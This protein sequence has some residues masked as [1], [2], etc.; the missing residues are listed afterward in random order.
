MDFL[1]ENIILVVSNNQKKKMLLKLSEEKQLKN[2]KFMTLK[3]LITSLTF[4]YDEKAIAYLMD[5]YNLKYSNALMYLKNIKYVEDKLYNNEKLDKLVKIKND[6]KPYL[7]YDNLFSKVIKNKKIVILN[8]DYI[9]KYE[10]N[11]LNKINNVEIIN[12]EKSSYIHDVYEFNSINDEIEF[13]SIKICELINS[14]ID[15]N[16]IKIINVNN[17]YIYHIKYIFDMHNIP[18]NITNESSIYETNMVKNFLHL[19]DNDKNILELNY[20]QNDDEEVYIFNKIIEVLNKYNFKTKKETKREMIINDLK[21]IKPKSNKYKNAVE[22]VNIDEV[23]DEDYVFMLNFNQETIPKIYKDEDY[24]SDKLKDIVGIEKSFELNKIERENIINKIKSIKNLTITYKLK[25]TFSSFYPSSLIKDLNYNV[26]KIQ[27]I[28]N[29]YSNFYNKVKLTNKLDNYVKYGD[30]SGNLEKL[31]STYNINYLT[32]SNEFNGINKDHLKEYLNNN[33]NLSYTSMNNY[34]ECKFKYYISN[35]L[36][37]NENEET[38]AKFIGNLFHYILSICFNK[39]FDFELE[40][41]KYTQDYDLTTSNK[42]FLKKLKEELK[43]IIKT[44]EKQYSFSN[45]K[46]AYYEN[47]IVVTNEIGNVKINFKGFIDKLMY[48]KDGNKTLLV[49]IDY[50]T[51]INE[52]NLSNS[53]Y[54]LNLQLPVYLYLA[55]HSNK[56]ENAKVIG[57]YLQKILNS[58]ISI[59]ENKTYEKQKEENLKLQGY[60][61]DDENLIYEFDKTYKDSSVIKS[62]K[63]SS[64]GFSR[65]TKILNEDMMEKLSDLVENKINDAS[66]GIINADFKINPKKIG[67]KNVSCNFCK[68]KDI[69][70]VKEN[71][72]EILEENKD[73][74]FLK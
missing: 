38:F 35:V 34:Y 10:R 63:I 8:K 24:L 16:K 7:I 52:I 71:D 62:M 46:D 18:I 29:N 12:E 20:N 55:K 28:D 69:C 14:N 42:F 61:I 9:N 66:N 73:L 4:D 60:S 64:E 57:F 47:E 37:I 49:I 22:I 13:V 27:N 40:F 39:D 59:K 31:Y 58:E 2:I 32:Y 19:F 3:N 44:I 43:F 65:Y 5:N 48:K 33:I 11:I 45:F 51:G 53:I 50:K 23:D 56:I 70:F 67:F 26:I 6:L 25:T 54:G 30:K 1:K 36:K 41:K 15:I 21:N 68:Y 74:D 17:D 72:I